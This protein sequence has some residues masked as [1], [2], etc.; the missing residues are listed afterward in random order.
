MLNAPVER[1]RDHHTQQRLVRG[2]VG[3][4]VVTMLYVGPVGFV[5]LMGHGHQKSDRAR[6]D[7]RNIESAVKG[8]RART[9]AWPHEESW[10][11]ELVAA[12]ILERCPLDSW[13]HPYQYRLE[14]ADGGDP[15]PVV[16][17]L[18]KDGLDGTE[19]DLPN[20]WGSTRP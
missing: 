12:Q 10:C 9:G 2:A 1:E 14:A 18:G 3:M 5:M 19:D 11:E 20:P 8:Y 15:Q 13:D 17:C 4:T 6:V 16:T 7:I